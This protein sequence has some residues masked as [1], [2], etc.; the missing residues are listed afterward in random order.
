MTDKKP[1]KGR[2]QVKLQN[3]EENKQASRDHGRDEQ[4]I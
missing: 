1:H 2:V 3:L 4:S